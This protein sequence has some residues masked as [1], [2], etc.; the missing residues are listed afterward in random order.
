M[1]VKLRAGDGDRAGHET[2][3]EGIILQSN[4][5][6]LHFQNRWSSLYFLYCYSFF[7]E[8]IPEG[9]NPGLRLALALEQGELRT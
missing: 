7:H 3:L 4:T 2:L 8:G 5:I 1:A 6:R 9:E